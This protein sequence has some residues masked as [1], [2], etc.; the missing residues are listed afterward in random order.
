MN[1]NYES[2]GAHGPP[3]KGG[4]GG[5]DLPIVMTFIFSIEISIH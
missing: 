1:I 2:L 5:K 4:G 3:R